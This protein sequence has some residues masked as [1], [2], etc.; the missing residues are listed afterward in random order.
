MFCCGLDGAL[1]IRM[2]QNRV[3]FADFVKGDG[4]CHH[5]HKQV[6]PMVRGTIFRTRLKRGEK[7]LGPWLS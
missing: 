6:G 5:A 1:A 7:R 3:W 2:N 4:V